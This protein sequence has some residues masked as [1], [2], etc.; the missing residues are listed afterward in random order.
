MQQ[1]RPPRS[2]PRACVSSAQLL[3][4]VPPATVPSRCLGWLRGPP[5]LPR[6]L[7]W[8]FQLTRGPRP[9]LRHRPMD[10]LLHSPLA[11]W[12]RRTA[13]PAGS[14]GRA[15]SRAPP[16]TLATRPGEDPA[17]WSSA[18]HSRS[19]GC[20]LRSGCMCGLGRHAAV[21]QFGLQ[22]AAR[23]GQQGHEQGRLQGTTPVVRPC[24]VGRHAAPP[25]P[26]VLGSNTMHTL[27]LSGVAGNIASPERCSILTVCDHHTL[28]V[29]S[30]S[31]RCVFSY[32]N[33]MP[34]GQQHTLGVPAGPAACRTSQG[35]PTRQTWSVHH[36]RRQGPP[37]KALV[38]AH[39]S[40]RTVSQRAPGRRC[41]LSLHPNHV[42][43]VVDPSTTW[44]ACHWCTTESCLTRQ[45]TRQ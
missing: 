45:P 10:T 25:K 22:R 13:M 42:T 16:A 1:R 17:A 18:H 29:E 14:R 9:H 39:P 40:L 4:P 24:G 2:S 33:A 37:A 15:G 21:A 19:L 6:R 7:P 31:N 36:M 20:M 11:R 32:A 43:S 12:T 27:N 35:L 26:Q 8:L 23:R 38:G 30:H 34:P 3:S 44:S 41:N 28:G 5:W